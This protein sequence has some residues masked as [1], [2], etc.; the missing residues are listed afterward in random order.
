LDLGYVYE[1]GKGV[2]LDYVAAYTWYR[3][4]M[5]GGEQR[6]AARLKSLSALLTEEQLREATATAAKLSRSFSNLEAN[7]TSF[8]LFK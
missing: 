4:A 6:A 3:V 8:G 7:S 5:N 1:Q 2:P